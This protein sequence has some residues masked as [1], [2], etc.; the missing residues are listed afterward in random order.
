M[1]MRNAQPAAI[2]AF[3]AAFAEG[4]LSAEAEREGGVVEMTTKKVKKIMLQHYEQISKH[5]F[6]ILFNP[7][8]LLHYDNAD[9]LVSILR[10]PEVAPTLKTPA[11][12]FRHVCRTEEAHD[13][14]ITEYR[15][16]FSSLLSGK[17]MSIADFFAGF[18]EG[19]MEDMKEEATRE[20]RTVTKVVVEAFFAGRVAANAT[21]SGNNQIYLFRLLLDAMQCLLHSRP[22][23][24]DEETDLNAA[25]MKVCRNERN[26][27]AML[28]AM[29][30]TISAA[31]P[32]VS[33]QRQ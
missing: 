23:S 29:E 8:A 32:Q 21:A 30:E 6:D 27:S 31:Q 3:F 10:S 26:L 22:V 28:Q 9:E 18:P 1:I 16:N 15:R 5:F 19:Y 7:L 13:D 25:F 24:M 4:I 33:Q 20:V 12:L 11:D 2:R 14:M 17:V